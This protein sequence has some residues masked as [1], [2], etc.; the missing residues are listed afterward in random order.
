MQTA[1]AGVIG[2]SGYAGIELTRILAAHPRVELRMLASDRWQG[3]TVER[4]TGVSGA[5]GK[6]K[7]APQEKAAQ[8]A[9]E[10]QVVFL[11]TPAEASLQAAP[12]LLE[13]G[14]R[15]I[16]LSGAFRLRDAGSFKKWYGLEHPRPDLL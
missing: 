4:R 9:R 11:A 13:S 12:G 2:A 14:A 1:T 16:D 15:V 10:C 5:A 3:E 6:L 7:Y 8:L